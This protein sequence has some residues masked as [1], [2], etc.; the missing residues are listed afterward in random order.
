MGGPH[1]Q[2]GPFDIPEVSDYVPRRLKPWIYIFFLLIIQFS[3]GVYLAAVSDMV[4]TKALMQE[5]ILMAG[6]ASLVGMTIN[7][8][9]MFRMKFRYSNR[10][11]LLACCM[12]LIAANMICAYSD[13]V[14][15]LVVTCF[16][17]GWF[18]MQATLQCNSTIQ[19]WITPTRDMAVWF[20]YIY[21]VVDGVIQLS[22]IATIYSAHFVQWEYMHIIM[23]G[24]LVLMML[25]ILVLMK[26]I[27]CPMFIPLLGV[28]WI[29][30][31]LW[32]VALLCL[33]FVCVY[34]N[35]YDWWMAEEICGAS[36]LG[37]ACLAINLWRATFLRHPYISF[38]ALT[39][40]NVVRAVLV[41]FVFYV[42]MATEHVF[43]HSYA[44][45]ILGFDHV[46][47]I[48]L[49]WYVVFGV[50]VGSVF[51]FVTFAVR[52]WRYKTMAAIGFA[53][54]IM[55][56]AWFYFYIDYGVEKEALFVPLFCR[57]MASVIIS[58]ILLTSIMQSGLPFQIFP[59]GL[60]IN[61]FAS[62]VVS[63][64][65]TP[66][67]MGELLRHTVAKNA[68]L[69]G[70]R[71]VDCN[72]DVAHIPLGDLYGMVQAQALLVS[73]KEIYGWLLM[74]ALVFFVLILVSYAPVRPFAI[75]PK[76]SSIRRLFKHIVR[77]EVKLGSDA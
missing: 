68:S 46:N 60:A 17:A 77:M 16:V 58:I 20:S 47:L 76:W 8:A 39:N 53:L 11:L 62:A 10:V 25:M 29:G 74:A 50:V 31:L 57:G 14:P 70:V 21:I 30:A 15:L 1:I 12:V 64:T 13:S 52:R 51:S 4:G 5:D 43:E 63:A 67:I 23:T 36:L 72:P 66:A 26:A 32:S 27:R 73:M 71:I 45:G 40:R 7:F 48:D 41:Y 19:L 18:R 28:D 44:A 55:Y 35:F 22:G 59:Q 69:L 61:G 34:G 37:L 42:L 2:Q 24:M 33:T 49:N 3:G 75:F 38:M 9:V 65:V 6:Y 54:A 56:L